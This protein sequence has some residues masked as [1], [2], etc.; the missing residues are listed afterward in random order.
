MGLRLSR[1]ICLKASILADCWRR[2]AAR[3]VGLCAC[4]L[5]PAAKRCRRFA[6][7]EIT[8]LMNATAAVFFTPDRPLELTAFPLPQLLNGEALVE[9]DC[10]TLCGSDL[11]SISGARSVPAPTILGHEIVGHV[12]GVQGTVSDVTGQ[13]VNAGDRVSWSIAASCGC[14]FFCDVGPQQKCEQLFKYGHQQISNDYPLSGGLATHCHL[15]AGTTIVKVPESLADVIASPAG[16][17]TATVAAALR[18]AGSWDGK[19]IVIHGAGMLGLTAA[20]MARSRGAAHVIVTDLDAARV[21]QAASFGATH[22][23][24][25]SLNELTDGRGADIVL[26]MSGS[27]DAMESSIDLLRIGGRLILVGAVFPARPLSLQADQLV[28]RML[29][30][31]GVHNYEPVD[32]QVAFEFLAETAGQYPFAE[33]IG[34]EFTLEQINE[35]VAYASKSGAYRVAIRPN[36][37]SSNS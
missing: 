30:V 23:S 32:L 22:P 13:P 18:T 26:D 21:Q 34:R 15:V 17:A 12:V 7:N 24:L 36:A 27:P 35:A 3:M 14:C 19:T 5:T 11:H 6:T 31:E 4:G 1:N 2:Y 10:C 16:C 29:R 28:R 25:D 33:L 9:V 20:A 8:N 37:D